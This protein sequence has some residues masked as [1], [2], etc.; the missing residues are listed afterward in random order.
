MTVAD[1]SELTKK[2]PEKSLTVRLKKHA[3]RDEN[4]RIS[5]RHR[6]GGNKRKYR[7]IDFTMNDR[8]GD[9]AEVVAI[10]YDPNRSARIALIRFENG[11]RRYI[12]APQGLLVGASVV[13]AESAE[14]Q[15]GNRMPLSAIPTGIP[16]HNIEME[17]GRGG[18][19]VRSAGQAATLLAKEGDYGL[20]RL[21]SGEM[22][23]IHIRSFAS[24]GAVS[25]PEH[26]TVR[27]AKA[28]RRRHMGWR[29]TVRGKAMNV[30][31]HPHGGGE[32]R[33][34][35]GMKHPKTPWGKPAL[36]VKTRRNKRSDRFI[37]KRRK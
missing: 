27:L 2:K 4:G 5:I 33:S 10:E 31:V 8:L 34:S 21:P 26:N 20:I 11:E 7:L 17:P 30:H 29:P 9:R 19:L 15:V 25:F 37:V 3:G 18:K 32:A 14:A 6:G 16:I 13:A 22:R 12:L 28:G 36:G 1:F 35:I 23:R 24:I